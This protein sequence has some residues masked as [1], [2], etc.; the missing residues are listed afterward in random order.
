MWFVNV[1]N[2][3]EGHAGVPK[4]KVINKELFS[5]AARAI[6]TQATYGTSRTCAWAGLPGFSVFPLV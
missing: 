6:R 3:S 5:A 2:V 1:V 4:T